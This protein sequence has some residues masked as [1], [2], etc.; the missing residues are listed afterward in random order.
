[1]FWDQF[2]KEREREREIIVILKKGL[3]CI[4]CL[5][6][7]LLEY[8]VNKKRSHMFWDQFF[9]ERERSLLYSRKA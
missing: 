4:F 8:S 1:M 5:I 7:T 6:E 2:F 9:K 3:T